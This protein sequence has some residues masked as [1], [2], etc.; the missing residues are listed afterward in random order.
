MNCL[1][2]TKANVIITKP[3]SNILKSIVMMLYFL[4]W[5]F[6]MAMVQVIVHDNVPGMN[7]LT[8]PFAV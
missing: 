2:A 4:F 1:D 3:K 7:F 6:M 5:A 8:I